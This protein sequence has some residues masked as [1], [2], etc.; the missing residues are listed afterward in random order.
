MDDVTNKTN[1]GG[2]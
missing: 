2:T 1:H